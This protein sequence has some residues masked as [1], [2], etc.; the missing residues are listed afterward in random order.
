MAR[1]IGDNSD[2]FA[3]ETEII[4]YLNS[5]KYYNN[6]NENM[7]SFLSFLFYDVNIDDLPIRASKPAGMVKPDIAITVNEETRY[8]SVKKG[9]GNSVHQEKLDV[10]VNYLRYCG[11]N[12]TIITYLKEFHYGDGSTDGNGGNRVSAKEWLSVNPKKAL[13]INRA[14]SNSDFLISVFDRVLF[15]GNVSPAPVVDAIFHGNIN[16]ALWA[17]RDEIITYLLEQKNTTT[18]IHFSKLTYQVWN[19]NLNYNPNTANRRHVMQIKWASMSDDLM[20]IK[21]TRY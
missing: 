12:D 10:F 5:A 3:N 9:S 7:K 2:G 13:K 20:Y 15:V 21:K 11:I 16:N 4:N 8:V 6:L 14:F 17:S 1:I 19:R 18:N